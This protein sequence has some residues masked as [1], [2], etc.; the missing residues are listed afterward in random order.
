M[1]KIFIISWFL[2]TICFCFI[3]CDIFAKITRSKRS[4]G[5][6]GRTATGRT[7]SRRGAIS[8]SG[9]L[10]TSTSVLQKPVIKRFPTKRPSSYGATPPASRVSVEKP[11]MTTPPTVPSAPFLPPAPLAPSA[12]SQASV[13]LKTPSR[14][15]TSKKRR[16]SNVA[17]T[18]KS[19]TSG[20]TS[21][22]SP[23]PYS[24]P[25]SDSFVKKSSTSSA[26]PSVAPSVG[27]SV[28]PSVRKRGSGG[29]NLFGNTATEGA[30]QEE[31]KS[32]SAMDSIFTGASFEDKMINLILYSMTLPKSIPGF[33]GKKLNFKYQCDLGFSGVGDV[34][35]GFH[36]VRGEFKLG[37]I[38]LKIITKFL[39]TDV[40]KMIQFFTRLKGEG[41]F[42]LKLLMLY[43]DKIKGVGLIDEQKFKN[44]ALLLLGRLA[45]TKGIKA[46][47]AFLGVLP[48]VLKNII[49]QITLPVSRQDLLWGTYG[50]DGEVERWAVDLLG[51]IQEGFDFESKVLALDDALTQLESP[52]MAHMAKNPLVRIL[53]VYFLTNVI[54]DIGKIFE[55]D[56]SSILDRA[57]L[58]VPLFEK[59]KLDGG[60]LSQIL[61]DSTIDEKTK[62]VIYDL[63]TR[64]LNAVEGEAFVSKVWSLND[65]GMPEGNSSKPLSKVMDI[66]FKKTRD[67]V[68]RRF[69]S[70]DM[71]N[72]SGG[73]SVG[74]PL[75][76]D[77]YDVLK[78]LLAI[79]FRCIREK[80]N[81]EFFVE[82]GG[83]KGFA[84]L[85]IA[86]I[87]SSLPPD[88]Q[89]EV[90]SMVEQVTGIFGPLLTNVIGNIQELRTQ[91]QT[92]AKS[93][94]AEVEKAKEDGDDFSVRQL[95]NLEKATQFNDD[96]GEFN[97]ENEYVY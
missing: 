75:L 41:V 29:S 66:W 19:K 94:E 84:Q 48:E 97:D 33:G 47:S 10:R 58:L 89:R 2:L 17:T 87:L 20:D 93:V 82:N 5:I 30:R 64:V 1:K 42:I 91:V 37:A 16:P 72:V 90:D 88:I 38:N 61:R 28:V 46:P 34:G 25:S 95:E 67:V 74:Q 76:L 60:L 56:E 85:E 4:G 9:T 59:I 80:N 14:K 6:S 26:V 83:I 73:D 70:V 86:T 21:S 7:S 13:S 45:L 3:F 52:E 77:K 23:P 15:K 53:F 65:I 69:A 63:E 50:K 12:S 68:S 78:H 92:T 43:N 22:V 18:T 35:K 54:N 49:D 40:K 57:E 27:P 24:S 36:S 32:S 8:S 44:Y 11:K 39:P 79:F 71:P 31:K 51:Q 55:L 81:P 62:N 96:D